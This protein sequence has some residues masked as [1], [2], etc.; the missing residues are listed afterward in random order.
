MMFWACSV[1]LLL[2]CR[3]CCYCIE[4]TLLC[5]LCKTGSHMV[6]DN[7]QS[8]GYS[9]LHAVKPLVAGGLE[10]S[11]WNARKNHLASI[12]CKKM[13]WRPGLRPGLRW[14]AYSAPP[15]PLAGEEGTGCPLPKNPTPAFCLSGLRLRPS[16]VSAPIITPKLKFWLRAWV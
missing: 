11:F 15:E 12:E 10:R 4:L 7:H 16:L 9:H 13:L 14:G 1:L 5:F 2:S 3:C 6:I 8:S